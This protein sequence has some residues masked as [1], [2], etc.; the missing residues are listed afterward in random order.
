M[1]RGKKGMEERACTKERDR[2]TQMQEKHWSVAS[3]MCPNW[4]QTWN[5]D[6]CPDWELNP[7]PFGVWMM[8]QQIEQP[9]QGSDFL[10]YH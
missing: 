9:G 6:M 4:D 1:I 10:F 5:L 7:Q 3:H 8:H 2:E